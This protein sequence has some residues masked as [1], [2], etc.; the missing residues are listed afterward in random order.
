MSW[1]SD[2]VDDFIETLKQDGEVLDCGIRPSNISKGLTPEFPFD[3]GDNSVPCIRF[4][5]LETREVDDPAD[6][7]DTGF[8]RIRTAVYGVYLVVSNP[9]EDKR[10]DELSDL[11]QAF[12]NA[13]YRRELGLSQ[14]LVIDEIDISGVEVAPDVL[15]NPYGVAVATVEAI[16]IS[17]RK[18]RSGRYEVD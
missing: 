8:N 18:E 2:L 1:E 4:V 7:V 10:L 9:K 15:T 14:G 11:W 6:D 16:T 12:A 3:M 5:W 17:D 13:V